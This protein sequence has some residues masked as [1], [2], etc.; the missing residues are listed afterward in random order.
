[1]CSSDLLHELCFR[2]LQLQMWKLEVAEAM[3]VQGLCMFPRASEPHGDGGLSIAKDPLGS[4]RI[5]PFGQR[6]QHDGDLV[7]GGFQTVQGSAVPGSEGGATGLTTKRLDPL[8]MAMLA[9]AHQ[10]VDPGVSDPKVGALP[11]GT[12][13]PLGVY[14]FGSS[15]STFDLRP[16]TH[17]QRHWPST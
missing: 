8:G 2:N 14:A 7:R 12:S 13:E 15:S 4:R 16:G 5:Q 1:V 6:R 10:R 3:L 11:V 9:I 17:R